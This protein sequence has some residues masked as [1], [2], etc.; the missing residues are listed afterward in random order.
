LGLAAVS[1]E[2]Q[3]Y[4]GGGC[5]LVWLVALLMPQASSLGRPGRQYVSVMIQR[6]SIGIEMV[7]KI[8]DIAHL[9][10]PEN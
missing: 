4:G 9:I 10:K 1:Q 7:M 3:H 5:S 6:A 8:Y 2:T